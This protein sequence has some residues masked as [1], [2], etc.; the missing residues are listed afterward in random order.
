MASVSSAGSSALTAVDRAQRRLN[1]TLAGSNSFCCT[2]LVRS[3]T[4]HLRAEARG[5]G[6]ITPHS[7]QHH[8]CRRRAGLGPVYKG[9]TPSANELAESVDVRDKTAQLCRV[10]QVEVLVTHVLRSTVTQCSATVNR[11]RLRGGSDP[12]QTYLPR[13]R[14]RSVD[15][16]S[17]AP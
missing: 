14:A 9:D 2:S 7:A 5:M 10:L 4:H 17:R 15:A 3:H 13:M 11:Q 16:L 1:S 12:T 6:C 8:S